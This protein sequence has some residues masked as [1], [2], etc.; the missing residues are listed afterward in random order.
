ME[1][2]IFL[3]ICSFFINKNREYVTTILNAKGLHTK[4]GIKV[5]VDHNLVKVNRNEKLEMHDLL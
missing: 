2:D 3:D 4:I 1:K 5:L